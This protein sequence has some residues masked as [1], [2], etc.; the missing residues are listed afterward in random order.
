MLWSLIYWIANGMGMW[1]LARGMGL[2]VSVVGAFATMGIV[3][4]GIT[5]P[6]TPG[7]VGQFQWFTALG[8]SLYGIDKADALPTRSCCTGSRSSGTSASARRSCSPATCASPI[9]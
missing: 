5:L 8:L 6:N 9:S 2:D 4:V 7:L 3:A 1:V